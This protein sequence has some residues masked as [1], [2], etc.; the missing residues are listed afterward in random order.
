[1]DPSERR[2]H[3]RTEVSLPSSLEKTGARTPSVMRDVS[4]GGAFM[5][6]S[7]TF[8]YG[9]AVIVHVHLPGLDQEIAI[10]ST[11]RWVNKEGCGVQFGVMGV[12]ETHALVELAKRG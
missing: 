1:M 8:A 12:R 5:S 10:P 7:E 2:R 11:V 3:G 9:D 4:I 6:T